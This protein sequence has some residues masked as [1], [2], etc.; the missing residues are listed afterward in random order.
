MSVIRT[1]LYYNLQQLQGHADYALTNNPYVFRQT[2]PDPYMFVSNFQVNYTT[3][4][5]NRAYVSYWD[6]DFHS[7]PTSS[8]WIH[9]REHETSASLDASI[10]PAPQFRIY[11]TFQNPAIYMGG[12]NAGFYLNNMYL[13][14]T[15]S[16]VDIIQDRKAEAY[17]NISDPGNGSYWD[18]TSLFHE[19]YNHPAR[20]TFGSFAHRYTILIVRDDIQNYNL[21]ADEMVFFNANANDINDQPAFLVD[22]PQ[23]VS[24][25]VDSVEVSAECR[26]TG[27]YKGLGTTDG[28]GGEAIWYKPSFWYDVD[29]KPEHVELYR[30]AT[31]L[32][33]SMA[34]PI[35]TYRQATYYTIIKNRWGRVTLDEDGSLVHG[36]DFT[37]GGGV[38]YAY[39]FTRSI[40]G[41]NLGSFK[42]DWTFSAWV[43]QGNDRNTKH[44]FGN[45]MQSGNTANRGISITCR[46]SGTY[47]AV[48]L[49]T[50]MPSHGVRRSYWQLRE[51]GRIAAN[52]STTGFNH[53]LIRQDANGDGTLY[54][55]VNGVNVSTDA[56]SYGSFGIS[57]DDIVDNQVSENFYGIGFNGDYSDTESIFRNGARIDDLRVY[58]RVLSVDEI[59][60]LASQRGVLGAP[61][62]I[63]SVDSLTFDTRAQRVRVDRHNVLTTSIES[64]SEVKGF[65]L[66]TK[67]TVEMDSVQSHSEN[68]RAGIHIPTPMYD[69]QA[70]SETSEADIF[71]SADASLSSVQSSSQ[72]KDVKLDLS[73]AANPDEVDVVSQAQSVSVV[74]DRV[75]DGL[76]GETT[77]VSASRDNDNEDTASTENFVSGKANLTVGSGQWKDDLNDGGDHSFSDGS[78]IN[79][80]GGLF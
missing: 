71:Y 27:Q 35:S 15:S 74:A 3:D 57:H 26:Q 6:Y 78:Q 18:I 31:Y 43:D 30:N 19:M 59:A 9:L 54:L 41:W 39:M 51:S 4:R 44:V 42:R 62:S 22:V 28:E 36:V 2:E 45:R 33:T 58:P 37:E 77:W 48:E 13:A 20:E 60:R 21:A 80:P 8:V 72:S 5:I 34:E 75:L 38:A 46:R 70:Q 29:V 50:A 14:R 23:N 56:Y 47:F 53:I 66:A 55:Y 65:F 63:D 76:G 61:V 40:F 25:S 52:V 32:S 17:Q 16:Y 11:G 68:L 12:S 73:G 79:I 10:T 7:S 24:L 1:T 64:S 67:N 49:L 69:L